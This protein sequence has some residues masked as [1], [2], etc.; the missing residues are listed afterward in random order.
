MGAG[1]VFAPAWRPASLQS[2]HPRPRSPSPYL[3]VSATCKLLA[4]PS[5]RPG[6]LRLPRPARRARSVGTFPA[7]SCCSGFKESRV[8]ISF[9]VAKAPP[10]VRG[11]YFSRAG[12]R[13]ILRASSG[14][15]GER[16]SWIAAAA[17]A[18]AG[19]EEAVATPAG[20]LG[21][22]AEAR[23]ESRAPASL[24]RARAGGTA[25][26]PWRG[27]APRRHP[28]RAAAGAGL[29]PPPPPPRSLPWAARLQP[30]LPAP[31]PPA[32]ARLS[33]A[34][35]STEPQHC[36]PLNSLHAARPSRSLPGSGA[37]RDGPAAEL[38][39][40]RQLPNLRFLVC[41]MGSTHPHPR[42]IPRPN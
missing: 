22:R 20:E 19:D 12:A 30:Q 33:P 40:G 17:T 18:V 39:P 7:A 35:S 26:A 37:D 31:P 8:R 11:G 25:G 28:P 3:R 32:A 21:R 9:L 42:V 14:K 24:A 2:P 5:R 10:A 41:K 34:R 15:V 36:L 1:I 23:S 16:E 6:S 29:R 13:D 27:E 4:E 38:G